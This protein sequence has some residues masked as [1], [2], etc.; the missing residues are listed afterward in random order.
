MQY[1]L[2]VRAMPANDSTP[3]KKRA[4]TYAKRWRSKKSVRTTKTNH[5]SI[6][7]L[8]LIAKTRHGRTTRAPWAL[9]VLSSKKTMLGHHVFMFLW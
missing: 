3:K 8:L 9:Q 6:L 1:S 4:C 2:A 5:T 7:L